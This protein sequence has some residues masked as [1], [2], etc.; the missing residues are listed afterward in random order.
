MQAD[1]TQVVE[2]DPTRGGVMGGPEMVSEGSSCIDCS[3]S[4]ATPTPT[5]DSFCARYSICSTHSGY[6]QAGAC[7]S[8][9]SKHT[10]PQSCV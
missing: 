2:W 5:E 3:F 6:H 7:M 8:E 4:G 10:Q 9:L 1:S